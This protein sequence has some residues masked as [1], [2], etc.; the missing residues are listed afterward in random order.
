[1]DDSVKWYRFYGKSIIVLLNEWVNEWMN[2]F[3]CNNLGI[4][5]VEIVKSSNLRI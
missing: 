1:M 5:F 4:F 2:I 3:I